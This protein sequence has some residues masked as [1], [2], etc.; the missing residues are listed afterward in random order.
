LTVDL[1]VN[2]GAPEDIDT[3]VKF[4]QEI[5]LRVIGV[6]NSILSVPF[7]RVNDDFLLLRRTQVSAKRLPSAKRL[8][9][10]VRR[11]NAILS[12]RLTRNVEMANWAAGDTRIDMIT[13]DQHTDTRLR[14][15]TAR[16]AAKGGTLLE[17]R[18]SA[19]LH[20]SGL[21]RSRLLKIFRENV[22][23]AREANMQVVLTSGARRPLELR[24][25]MAVK[26]IGTLLGVEFDDMSR[27]VDQVPRSM[28]ER[29][30]TKLRSS[31]VAEGVEIV[32]GGEE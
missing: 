30:L 21:A 20:S 3:F 8:T 5:G 4:A 24:S 7:Q 17:V 27:I 2:I 6:P 29:N 31:F 15:T 14:R 23:I 16:L 25:P 11:Q 28:I 32:Q 10:R 1:G 26:C 19:L 13:V 12:V 22:A 18:F 9:E